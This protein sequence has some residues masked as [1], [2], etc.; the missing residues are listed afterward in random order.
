[1]KI[2]IYAIKDVK[3]GFMSTWQSHSDETAT[4]AFINT[5]MPY[6]QDFELWKIGIYDDQLGIIENDQKFITNYPEVNNEIL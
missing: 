6:K 4:R 1:M 3:I 5:E 2:G